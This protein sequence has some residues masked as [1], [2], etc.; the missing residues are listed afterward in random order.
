[1]REAELLHA[2]KTGLYVVREAEL[3]HSETGLYVVR[4]WVKQCMILQVNV[5]ACCLV[6]FEV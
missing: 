2:R 4:E 3:L 5:G 6:N 1:M